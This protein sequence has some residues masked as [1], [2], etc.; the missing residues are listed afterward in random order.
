MKN[1]TK[2]TPTNYTHEDQP[3]EC[4]GFDYF[5]NEASLEDMYGHC[6]P[7][8]ED[9]DGPYAVCLGAPDSGLFHWMK[10]HNVP[11]AKIL[12]DGGAI[13]A[14]S[15]LDGEELLDAVES[16]RALGEAQWAVGID[17]DGIEQ[18]ACY[19]TGRTPEQQALLN[20][21]I[22]Y[23]LEILNVGEKLRWI[24]SGEIAFTDRIDIVDGVATFSKLR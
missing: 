12:C 7:T 4:I 15:T 5:E 14:A 10:K 16:L 8:S 18:F 11:N 19:R 17:V 6:E 20:E 21:D 22:I 13:I 9:P 3:I 2:T 23:A 24:L 1:I